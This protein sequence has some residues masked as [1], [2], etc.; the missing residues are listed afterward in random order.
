MNIIEIIYP[1]CHLRLY[2]EFFAKFLLHIANLSCQ[3]LLSKIFIKCLKN[4]I[5]LSGP[6]RTSERPSC[7]FSLG[8]A[9]RM[10]FK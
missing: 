6:N 8:R 7:L 9:A 2:S 10:Q 1:D 4:S 3:N 5:L